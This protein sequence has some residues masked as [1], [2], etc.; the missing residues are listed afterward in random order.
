MDGEPQGE[1]SSGREG[2]GATG[3][4]VMG[5]VYEMAFREGRVRERRIQPADRPKVFYEYHV[6][7]HGTFPMHMLRHDG[8]WPATGEDAAKIDYDLIAGRERSIKLYSYR[9]PT[10]ERWS[11][12]GWSVGDNALR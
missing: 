3:G 1:W 10:I 6:T 5:N 9:K 4:C 12:F 11:S 2:V 8:A 7:G